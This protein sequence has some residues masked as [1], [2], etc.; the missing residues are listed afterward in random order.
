[1]LGPYTCLSYSFAYNLLSCLVDRAVGDDDDPG[2]VHGDSEVCQQFPDK[3]DLVV[4]V[5]G[6]HRGAGVHQEHQVS[7]QSFTCIWQQN[8]WCCYKKATPHHL[9]SFLNILEH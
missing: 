4:E 2:G 5:V 7:L 9:L 3:L 8:Y 6:A 1:L